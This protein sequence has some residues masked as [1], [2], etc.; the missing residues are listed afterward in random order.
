MVILQ[1]GLVEVILDKVD[2]VEDVHE[3]I[4]V[5]GVVFGEVE[6]YIDGC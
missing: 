2:G 4:Q 3:D 1:G 5:C 6:G